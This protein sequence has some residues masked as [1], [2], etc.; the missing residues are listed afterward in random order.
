MPLHSLVPSARI[1]HV[2]K[3]QVLSGVQESLTGTGLVKP[4][5]SDLDTMMLF[6]L[7]SKCRVSR[8]FL[9]SFTVWPW[10][11]FDIIGMS[12]GEEL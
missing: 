9:S 3:R 12:A 4:Q 1:L 8:A 7:N 11:G 5:P 2:T 10:A 6:G